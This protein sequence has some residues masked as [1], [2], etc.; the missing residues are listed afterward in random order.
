M[1][2]K[3]PV[4]F[5]WLLAAEIALLFLSNLFFAYADKSDQNRPERVDV[6]RAAGVIEA[7]GMPDASDYP[8]ITEI[9]PFDPS[10]KT[11]DAYA[12]AV[13]AE[14]QYYRISY[15]EDRGKPAGL[16]VINA[17]WT[18]V[19]VGTVIAALYI[20]RKL[21][22][23]FRDISALPKELAKGNLSVPIE[24]EKSRYYGEFLW[25]MDRLRAYMEEEKESRL[26]LEKEKK[27]LILTL[28]HDIKTPLSAIKLYDR[29]LATGL[30]DT[31][32]KRKEAYDGIKKN[33]EDL[34]AYVEEIRHAV[35]EDALTFTV[36]DHPWYLSE[37]LKELKGLYNE[38]TA[39]RRTKFTVE[40]CE[41][42]LL[43]GDRERALEV[44]QNLME[45][46]LKYGDG[47]EIAISFADEENCRLVT[48]SN[49][50]N[51]LK[52]E[53]ETNIFDSFYRGSN[54]AGIKGSGLGLYICRSLMRA[55]DGDIY[56][57]IDNDRFAV[58]A[59]FRKK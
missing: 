16:W 19:I 30:Y 21:L 42:C 12:V 31:E 40:D 7:G 24:E 11:N 44:L 57:K 28:S 33:A 27:T 3:R 54:T 26:A 52:E 45:N 1:K 47:R 35:R 10:E 43:S 18:V 56:A 53:E 14:G 55:M 2:H 13:S 49:T 15:R 5:I 25:G 41:D 38:K 6:A 17:V 48:V 4:F 32:E 36:E 29:A 9:K 50:G 51:T 23:P 46:A 37:V 59:V 34:E 22:R 8:Y 58:T 39:Q 20:Y